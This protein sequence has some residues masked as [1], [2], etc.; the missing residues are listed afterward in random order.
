MSL[1]SSVCLFSFSFG[2][3]CPFS[4]NPG[5]PD[6]QRLAGDFSVCRRPGCDTRGSQ[7][8]SADPDGEGGPSLPQT[9]KR[10]P[11]GRM[12][13]LH[14]LRFPSVPHVE[15][16]EEEQVGGGNKEGGAGGRLAV[17]MKM[18]ERQRK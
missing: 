3:I 4:P 16:E 12:E 18:K 13:I 14:L 7:Q 10:K 9:G 17:V 15:E 8:R 1:T 11:N 6:A 2:N 5:E